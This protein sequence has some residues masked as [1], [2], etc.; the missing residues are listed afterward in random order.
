MKPRSFS[1]QLKRHSSAVGQ[2]EVSGSVPG[3]GIKGDPVKTGSQDRPRQRRARQC[4]AGTS[5]RKRIDDDVT[6]GAGGTPDQLQE[7]LEEEPS[8]WAKVAKG[9]GAKVA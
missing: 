4:L 9:S 8:R 3:G 5:L 1:R 7:S 6:D 2:A